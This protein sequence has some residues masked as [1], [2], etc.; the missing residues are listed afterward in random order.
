[1][2]FGKDHLRLVV[3]DPHIERKRGRV[4]WRGT[5]GRRKR[6]KRGEGIEEGKTKGGG[7]IRKGLWLD[8]WSPDIG[9]PEE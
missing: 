7:G 3:L 5:E 1:M 2:L 9:D 4:R 8:D 6:K